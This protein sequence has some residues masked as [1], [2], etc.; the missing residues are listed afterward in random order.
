LRIQ[1]TVRFVRPLKPTKCPLVLTGIGI[2]II[3]ASAA[4]LCAIF[5]GRGHGAAVPIAFI[6]IITLVA[7]RC[8]ALAGMVG[9]LTAAVIFAYF[10]YKPLGTVSVD[11]PVARMNLAWL[12]LGGLACS[13]LL[14]LPGQPRH[15]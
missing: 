9:A 10:L 2:A 11:D 6:V 5:A 8:G 12:V 3:A 14:A 15:R 7:I 13:Y 1:I 4:L